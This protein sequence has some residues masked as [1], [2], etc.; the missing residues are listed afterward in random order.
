MTTTMTTV[1]IRNPGWTLNIDGQI[2]APELP[3]RVMVSPGV[4]ALILAAVWC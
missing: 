4:E 3:H 1:T 2:I